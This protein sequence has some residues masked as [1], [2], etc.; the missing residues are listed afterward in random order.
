MSKSPKNSLHR[1]RQIRNDFTYTWNLNRPNPK[2]QSRA[3]SARN[4]GVVGG[5]MLIEGC[6]LPVVNMNELQ[7]LLCGTGTTGWCAA[8]CS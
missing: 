7:G 8:P 5:E 1:E 3:V 4:W 6:S 2:K